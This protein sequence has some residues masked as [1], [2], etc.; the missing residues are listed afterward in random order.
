MFAPLVMEDESAGFPGSAAFEGTEDTPWWA[1]Q[2][3]WEK[4]EVDW[5]DDEFTT[6]VCVAGW[7]TFV[8]YMVL[9]SY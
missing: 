6:S 9:L 7:Q 8:M 2:F 4:V 3:E 5:Q 1:T